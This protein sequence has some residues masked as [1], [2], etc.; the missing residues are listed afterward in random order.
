MSWRATG[1]RSGFSGAYIGKISCGPA[2]ISVRA[3]NDSTML[4]VNRSARSEIDEGRDVPPMNVING[5][6]LPGVIS[7]R[8]GN[9]LA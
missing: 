9:R 7:N 8:L 1:E 4:A 3:P 5:V 6:E 2:K